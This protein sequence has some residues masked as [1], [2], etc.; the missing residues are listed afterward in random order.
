MNIFLERPSLR[1]TRILLVVL[2]LLFAVIWLAPPFS[3]FEGLARYDSVHTAME[4][5]SI[6][7]SMLVFGVAWN[8]YSRE[9]ASNT[10]VLATGLL[11]A[12]LLDFAHMMSYAGMPEWVTP[13]G[14]EKAINF[15]LVARLAFAIALLAVALRPWAPFRNPAARYW[16]LAA[17]LG[18]S[19][20]CYWVGLYHPD[21]LPHTF[22]EGQ[23][24]T[25]FKIEAEYFI[26]ILMMMATVLFWRQAHRPETPEATGL[27]AAAAITVLSELSFTLY[28][29]VTDIFNLLGHFYKVLAYLFVYHTVFIGSVHEPFQRVKQAEAEQQQALKKLSAV[30]QDTV[31]AIAATVEMRDPYTAGHQRRVA[32]LAAT[33]GGELGLPHERIFALHLA[34]VVHDLGKISLPAEILTKPGRLNEI[35]YTLVK[36]HPQ[37]GYDI[38]KEVEFPWPLAQFVLQHHERMDGSGYPNGLK[39]DDILLEAR[40]LAVADVVEAMSSHRPYRAGLGVVTALAEIEKNRGRLYDPAVVDATLRLFREKDYHLEDIS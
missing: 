31:Q 26:I 35:E 25:R 7:I 9:R 11:A 13:S 23:G 37:A 32:D 18:F 24:L 33:I 30:L 15:W 38:L 4:T 19:A 6:V 8:A 17:A 27:L 20:M 12:G 3:G 40:I 34:G 22:I 2:T 39:G 1:L 10:I 28:S 14:P 29:D 5:L 16:L 21:I 36:Q